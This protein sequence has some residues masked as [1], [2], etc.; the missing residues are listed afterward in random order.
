MPA[1]SFDKNLGSNSGNSSASV[2]LTTSN[3]AA[4]GTRIV[5][6]VS[7]WYDVNN[8]CSLSGGSLAWAKDKQ[9]D[10][11][12]DRFAIFSAPAPS[13]LAS[14][15]SLTVTVGGS[16]GGIFLGAASFFNVQGVDTTGNTTGTGTSWSSGTA[17][18]ANVNGLVIGGSGNETTSSTTS[19]PV[20]GTELHD[21]WLSGAQQGFA[22]GYLI[23]SSIAS[24]S[25][26]GTFSTSSTANTGALMIYNPVP[27]LFSPHRMPLGV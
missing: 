10:N 22:T 23:S 16:G 13:G 11:G 2:V 8:T 9:N 19:T 20:N 26:T 17:T 24:Q 4:A 21:A 5:V 15:T 3:A 25:I 1:V 6:L 27:D 14:S 12:S 18:N 7:W